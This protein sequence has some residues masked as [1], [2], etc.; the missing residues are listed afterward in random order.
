MLSLKKKRAEEA[1]VKA[2][3]AASE[4]P[5]P[6]VNSPTPP[7]SESG[8]APQQVAIFNRYKKDKN[9]QSGGKKRTPGE[10]RI[11]RGTSCEF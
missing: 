5:T 1:K 2:A 8:E 4:N 11:Q 6:S 9:A 10:I 3:Q 7:A